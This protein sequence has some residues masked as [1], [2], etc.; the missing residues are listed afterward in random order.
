MITILVLAI[1]NL[2][3]ILHSVTILLLGLLLPFYCHR[4]DIY[5]SKYYAEVLVG[6][7]WLRLWNSTFSSLDVCY[8]YYIGYV[9]CSI[10]AS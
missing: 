8:C 5:V 3:G 7:L 2:F 10:M 1:F 4:I 9:C 6:L